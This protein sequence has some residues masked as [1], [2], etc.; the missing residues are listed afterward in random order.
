MGPPR[1]TAPVSV[2]LAAAGLAVST[3]LTIAHFTTPDLL[4]CTQTG[5]VDCASVTTSRWSVVLGIPVPLLGLV[6]FLGMLVLSLP[7]A[8][9]SPRR[10]VH[11]ARLLAAVA[12]IGFV[13]WLIYAE[14]VLVGALCLWCT[15]AHVLAFGLF[16]IVV[17]TAPDLLT[18][19][20]D[21]H[22]YS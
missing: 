1:W 12:G 3:Y 15:V 21:A 5:L 13:L 14:L 11:L 19:E 17:V 4:V 16:A 18:R 9:R 7:V 20:A 10:E 8:W 6:W 22:P 2:A